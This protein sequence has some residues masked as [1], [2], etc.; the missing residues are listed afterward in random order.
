MKITILGAAGVRTP[1]LDVLPHFIELIRPRSRPS[2]FTPSCAT[3]PQQGP[4]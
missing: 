2:P 1:L 3:T 4:F